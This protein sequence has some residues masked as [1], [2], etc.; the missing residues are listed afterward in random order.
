MQKD[1]RLA[2]GLS[3]LVFGVLFFIR[4]LNIFSP[5]YVDVIYNFKNYPLIL[6]VIFL[7]AHKDKTPGIVL[8]AVSVL[9]R[10]SDIIKLTQH[11][12]DFVWPTLLIIAGVIMVFGMKKGKN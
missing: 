4:Q 3:L 11:V 2:W 10:L 5:S 12:S 9:F 1:S 6:G 7:L 8:I